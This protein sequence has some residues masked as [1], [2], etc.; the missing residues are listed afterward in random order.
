[1][2]EFKKDFIKKANETID[3]VDYK[4]SNN[5]EGLLKLFDL[6]DRKNI[7]ARKFD[8]L[9][10]DSQD[11][12]HKYRDQLE[13]LGEVFKKLDTRANSFIIAAI[14]KD[15]DLKEGSND[16]IPHSNF[17]DM[18]ELIVMALKNPQISGVSSIESLSML[19]EIYSPDTIRG[20]TNAI[21]SGMD[22]TPI[23]SAIDAIDV[24]EIDENE[25]KKIKDVFEIIKETSEK[26][27][28][29]NEKLDEIKNM[30]LKIEQEYLENVDKKEKEVELEEVQG[31]H[32]NF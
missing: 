19:R 15:K 25:I 23:I 18:K 29:N 13:I 8:G 21:T 1:M 16:L 12:V 9:Y 30:I 22:A 26:N 14:E 32:S 7:D 17:I 10:K 31:L 2:S 5:H 6:S 3:S 24:K 4:V 11:G 27:Q 20:K 28:G